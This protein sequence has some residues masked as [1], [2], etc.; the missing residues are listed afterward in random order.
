MENYQV[1]RAYVRTDNW[2]IS[3]KAASEKNAEKWSVVKVTE[4]SAGGLLFHTDT[5]Y[6]IGDHLWFQLHINPMI[7]RIFEF[8]MLVRGEIKNRR[9]HQNNIQNYG[10]QFTMISDGDRMKLDELIMRTVSIYRLEGGQGIE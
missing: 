10:V 8:E 6:N 9:E 1:Q 7:P 5:P 4:I 3:A 2:A